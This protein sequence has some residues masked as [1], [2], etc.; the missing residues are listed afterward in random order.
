MLFT[1]KADLESLKQQN[2][3]LQSEKHQLEAKI[4]ALQAMNAEQH[5]ELEQERESR[6]ELHSK[7]K[8]LLESFRMLDG[9]RQTLANHNDSLAREKAMLVEPLKRFTDV[10]SSLVECSEELSNL[11]HH[12]ADLHAQLTTL[13]ESSSAIDQFVDN[14][15][16]ISN[17][18]NLLALNAAIEAARAGEQGRGFAVV[19]DEVRT[20]ASRSAQTTEEITKITSDSLH[21]SQA[22][23]EAVKQGAELTKKSAGRAVDIRNDVANLSNL[24]N[25][26]LNLISNFEITSFIQT[27]KLDH[28]IWKR[29]VY[30]AIQNNDAQALESLASHTECRLGKWYAQV[31][32]TYGQIDAYRQLDTP[33][34]ALHNHGRKAL[35]QF[36]QGNRDA[37]DICLQKMEE[38]SFNVFTCL[39]NLEQ[40]VLMCNS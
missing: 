20:L 18:T 5:A 25:S 40:S 37:S 6:L 11:E 2:Q 34:Q 36:I 15:A 21:Q 10:V 8:Q 23:Q 31:E 4:D 24:S 26:M 13:A 1:K 22:A 39:D 38:A 35:E 7:N 19:A 9:V 16:D 14:I 29:S 3:Q 32:S 27:V 12:N 28:I 33:N 30:E 17:Q